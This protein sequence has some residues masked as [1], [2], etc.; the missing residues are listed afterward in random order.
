MA[1]ASCFAYLCTTVSL[2]V[3]LT[4]CGFA[5]PQQESKQMPC[6]VEDLDIP[7]MPACVIES[8]SGALFIPRKYWMHPA[9][10]RYGL[11][12]FTI[13]SFGRVYINRSGR[14]VIRNVG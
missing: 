7:R 5:S 3:C 13:D 4:L 1:L 11:S 12:G 14:I 6:V 9:F 8:H 2:F 10:N